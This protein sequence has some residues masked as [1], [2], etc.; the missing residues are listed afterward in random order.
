MND[1]FCLRVHGKLLINSI[2]AVGALKGFLVLDQVKLR[3]NGADCLPAVVTH[4]VSHN[5]GS[6]FRSSH[7]TTRLQ[8]TGGRVVLLATFFIFMTPLSLTFFSAACRL[9]EGHWIDEMIIKIINPKNDK[10]TKTTVRKMCLHVR[11]VPSLCDLFFSVTTLFSFCAC[12]LVLAWLLFIYL[13]FWR[14]SIVSLSWRFVPWSGW[15]SSYLLLSWKF[16]ISPLM[17]WST[18][19]NVSQILWIDFIQTSSK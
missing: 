17:T 13:A 19:Y 12:I 8:C 11:K 3:G 4:S 7:V 10:I 6:L 15:K 16:L 18:T 1:T 5:C 14:L 2:R 9:K